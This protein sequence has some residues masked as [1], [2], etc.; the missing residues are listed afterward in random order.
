MAYTLK[1]QN[2]NF[3]NINGCRKGTLNY[4]YKYQG[5]LFTNNTSSATGQR[6]FYSTYRRV[7]IDGVTTTISSSSVYNANAYNATSIGIYGRYTNSSYTAYEVYLDGTLVASGNYTSTLTTIYTYTKATSTNIRIDGDYV[8]SKFVYNITTNP[9]LPRITSY[10][11]DNGTIITKTYSFTIE[12]TLCN[13]TQATSI[14]VP[15]EED[16]KKIFAPDYVI[17]VNVNYVK[18]GGANASRQTTY[19]WTRSSYSSSTVTPTSLPGTQL[20]PRQTI[21]TSNTT[22]TNCAVY[23]VT[24]YWNSI[25]GRRIY[26]YTAT[27]TSPSTYNGYL[28]Y[29][30]PMEI[31]VTVSMVKL[32]TGHY[33]FVATPDYIWTLNGSNYNTTTQSSLSGQIRIDD[34]TL[35]TNIADLLGVSS[36]SVS[37]TSKKI[38][39]YLHVYDASKYYRIAGSSSASTPST[40]LARGKYD[41]A[42]TYSIEIDISS[43]SFN[44]LYLYQGNAESST[45]TIGTNSTVGFAYQY[46][47]VDIQYSITQ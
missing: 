4:A 1:D 18:F 6:A 42:G 35:Q 32:N 24:S 28:P 34:A 27:S 36:S 2:G 25:K 17:S 41:T 10:Q 12:P 11:W 8:D 22:Q 5:G 19:I 31:N 13:G 21:T 47:E 37:I 15:S 26:F 3:F 45:T 46:S 16:I 14:I 38:T 20:I 39:V 43:A 29:I 9:E 30:E 40:Y 33:R 7:L 44:Q 23:D